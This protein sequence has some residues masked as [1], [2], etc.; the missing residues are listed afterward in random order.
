MIIMKINN[1]RGGVMK[2]AV[3]LTELLSRTVI[4]EC[5]SYE[6]AEK[7]VEAAYKSGELILT[8][9]NSIILSVTADNPVVS[10]SNAT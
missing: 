6:D 10:K 3:R 9:D 7:K 2:F 5:D 4:V 8:A 1:S